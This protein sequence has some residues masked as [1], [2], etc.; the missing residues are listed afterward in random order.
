MTARKKKAPQRA[1]RKSQKGAAPRRVTRRK[2]QTVS[3]P[4]MPKAQKLLLRLMIPAF[5]VLFFPAA[6]LSYYNAQSHCEEAWESQNVRVTL[7]SPKYVSVGDMDEMCVTV[8]NERSD[9]ATITVTLAYTGISPCLT[10]DSG[11]HVIDFG[12]LSTWERA[13]RRLGIQFLLCGNSLLPRNWLGRQVQFG[14]WLAVDNEL[15]QLLDIVSLPVTP[16]ARARTLGDV[17]WTLLGGLAVWFLKELWDLVKETE[18]SA[19]K[20]KG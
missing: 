6:Y 16:I 14:V 7:N 8:V 12:S 9:T 20:A 13:T 3:V 15:P 17:T 10:K 1:P 11:S 5:V 2:E 4:K 19:V 18:Q